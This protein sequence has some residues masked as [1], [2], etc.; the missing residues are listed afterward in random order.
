MYIENE[1]PS[2]INYCYS[3]PIQVVVIAPTKIHHAKSEY[4]HARLIGAKLLKK[5]NYEHA[6]A[7]NHEE[8]R[9]LY[10]G[11]HLDAC[12]DTSM[13][14]TITIAQ[15]G[16]IKNLQVLLPLDLIYID[17]NDFND[18]ERE[19]LK[20][21]R[22]YAMRFVER[23]ETSMNENSDVTVY[24]D[25]EVLY[26]HTHTAPLNSRIEIRY[27]STHETMIPT[28]VPNNTESVPSEVTQLIPERS[29]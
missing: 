12:I 27:Y 20:S 8:Q 9:I 5:I 26:R 22:A 14:S 19:A 16:L 21:K 13:F 7:D 28:I 29:L 10:E 2:N 4:L 15:Q 6:Y 17:R 24:W 23:L 25:K 3:E 11:G 1:F 18:N